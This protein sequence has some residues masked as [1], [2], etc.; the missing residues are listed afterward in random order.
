[1][2]GITVLAA[3]L[4]VMFCIG[5]ADAGWTTLDAPGAT[6]T[7]ASGID[8]RNIVGVY[9]DSSNV[10]YSFLYVIPA[11]GVILLGSIGVVRVGRLRRR[12]TL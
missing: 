9:W 2:I 12:R 8:G 5:Y 7:A 10:H 3:A 6:W 1:M 4:I 11:P